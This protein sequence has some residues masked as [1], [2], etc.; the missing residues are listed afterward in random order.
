MKP[1]RVEA[2]R[3]GRCGRGSC[4]YNRP[5]RNF[6]SLAVWFHEYGPVFRLCA[7]SQELNTYPRR[8]SLT[9]APRHA[10]TH[11]SRHVDDLSVHRAP[12][13]ARFRRRGAI[14]PRGRHRGSED[15][16]RG[17]EDPRNVGVVR[18]CARAGLGGDARGGG[19]EGGCDDGGRRRDA[20]VGEA[21]AHE[22]GGDGEGRPTVARLPRPGRH[23]G[24]RVHRK[25]LRAQLRQP[26]L[27]RRRTGLFPV[28]ADPVL[29]HRHRVP[30]RR[31]PLDQGHRRRERSGRAA[32]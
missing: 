16:S 24:H 13:R 22:E 5:K 21:R 20:P 26:H 28:Q 10:V 31:L 8:A 18:H 17:C 3:A 11:H 29:V 6:G 7:M 32:G 14:H 12:R 4:P 15:R 19:D 27:R 9:S 1:W 23:R 2:V 30:A 25:L